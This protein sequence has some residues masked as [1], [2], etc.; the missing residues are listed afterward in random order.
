MGEGGGACAET[1]MQAATSVR[2]KVFAERL[3]TSH[4]IQLFIRVSRTYGYRV[5]LS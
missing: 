1:L 4:P 5:E 3:H 2:V